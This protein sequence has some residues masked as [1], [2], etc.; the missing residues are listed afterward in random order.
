MSSSVSVSRRK[1]SRLGTTRASSSGSPQSPTPPAAEKQDE[2]GPVDTQLLQEQQHQQQ[3]PDTVA[4]GEG[5]YSVSEA[6]PVSEEAAHFS[7]PTVLACLF[8]AGFA[9]GPP[10]DGIH[11]VV[12]LQVRLSACRPEVRPS[13][14]RFHAIRF[15]TL[16]LLSPC[17]ILSLLSSN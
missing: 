14:L 3:K 7:W 15:L 12:G 1:S 2:Q 13:P 10:L 16:S 5:V 11:S 9:L 6:R 17:P 8:A 4:S